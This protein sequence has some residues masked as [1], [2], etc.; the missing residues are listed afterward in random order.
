[1]LN[2]GGGNEITIKDNLHTIFICIFC[3]QNIVIL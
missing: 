2:I 1:M 3:C